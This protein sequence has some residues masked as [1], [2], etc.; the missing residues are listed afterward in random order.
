MNSLNFRSNNKGFTL[1]EVLV[2]VVILSIGLLAVA[3]MQT[4]SLRG[5]NS[6]LLRSQAVL[7]A[8]DILDRMRANR[9]AFNQYVIDMDEPDH[10][11]LTDPDNLDEWRNALAALTTPYTGMVLTDLAEWKFFLARN[12][13]SGEGSVAV[14]GNVVTVV[15][16]WQDSYG[17]ADEGNQVEMVTRL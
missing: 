17:G 11:S 2:A 4:T 14:N 13:P 15:V 8:E 9:V 6:A 10:S 7:G 3:G 1:V 16:Q 12:L 5:G